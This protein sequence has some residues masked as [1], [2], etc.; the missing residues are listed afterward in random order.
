MA[1][2]QHLDLLKKGANTWNSWRGNHPEIHPNLRGADLH[3][4]NLVKLDLS[5]T[6]LSNA[7]QLHFVGNSL[8]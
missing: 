4:A 3:G 7:L 2:R 6:D 5:T 1:N 8:P